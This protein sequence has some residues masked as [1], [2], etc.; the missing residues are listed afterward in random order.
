MNS[1]EYLD[2]RQV[3]QSFGRVAAR[4]EQW[5]SLQKMVGEDLLERLQWLKLVPQQILDVG[6]GVGRLSRALSKQYKQAHVYS[7]DIALEMVKLGHLDAPRWFSKQ[8]FVCA[9]GAHLPFADDSVDL[10]VSNLMLQWCNDIQV[11][12]AEFARV[13][14]PEGAL[15]FSTFG[16]DTL[17]ELR[18]SWA[19]VDNA[20]HVN[21]FLDM[22]NYGDALLQAGLSNPVM[23]VDR[24]QFTYSDAKQLMR[25]LKHIGA[26]NLTA[27]RSRSLTGKGKFQ[28]M[29]GAYEEYRSADGLLPATYEVVYGHAWGKKPLSVAIPISQIGRPR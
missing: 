22:H 14:K 18:E 16:P 21:R 13:L 19:S 9:D 23:D 1:P 17:K 26:H 2:K 29:L 11:V 8:H 4:Y 5:A 7:V 20:S 25:E 6:A 24:F 12:F 27:G 28:A 10:L 15:F 3:S